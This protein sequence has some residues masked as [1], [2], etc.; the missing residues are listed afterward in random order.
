MDQDGSFGDKSHKDGIRAALM[1]GREANATWK[2]PLGDSFCTTVLLVVLVASLFK[3]EI[4]STG[5]HGNN[6]GAITILTGRHY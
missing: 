5:V 6:G 4:T 2:E 1:S 3:K